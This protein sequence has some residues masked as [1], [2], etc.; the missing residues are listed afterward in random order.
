MKQVAPHRPPFD[1]VL[2][3]SPALVD[4]DLER[5]DGGGDVAEVYG[6]PWYVREER[7]D[8]FN[9]CVSTDEQVRVRA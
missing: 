6:E 2:G 1:P 4:E 8:A 7:A 9:V 3:Q 5:S